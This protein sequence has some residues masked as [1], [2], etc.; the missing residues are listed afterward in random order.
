MEE[1]NNYETRLDLSRLHEASGRALEQLKQ[2]IIGQE[3][4]LRL[5]YVAVLA[6]EHVLIEGVPGV[7]KTLAARLMAK[8]IDAGFSRIQFTPDL[9]PSDI[10]GTT[11]YNMREGSFTFNSGPVFS[12]IILADEINRAPA[13]TQSALFEVM[14]ERQ[15]SI[16]GTTYQMARPFLVIATQNPIEQEG[17]YQLPE[18]QLDRFLFKINVAYPEMEDE[19][20][21]LLH[22]HE[23]KGAD[24]TGLIKPVLEKA[25]VGEYQDVV[26]SVFIEEPVV[27]Y[28]AEII[29]K[30]RKQPSLY[31]GAS[32]RAAVALMHAA[33]AFAALQGRDFVTP[34]D[35]KY[36]TPH[37]LR[38]RVILTPEKEME[39]S[40]PDDIIAQILES[41]E[42][43]T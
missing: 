33:K 17:T 38:H 5:L 41:V 1:Q 23:N 40:R 32:P 9:M 25:D 13:K 6:D 26:R 34:E 29:Q 24:E 12:N 28:I 22:K 21:L 4:L 20:R 8:S 35:I 30:T 14:Q 39:G 15:A 37:V 10:L 18:A 42:V 2:H 27:R 16:D 31:L 7:A 43:P 19:V 11:V 3:E 36:L